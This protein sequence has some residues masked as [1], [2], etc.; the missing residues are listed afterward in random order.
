MAAALDRISEIWWFTLSWKYLIS[1]FLSEYIINCPGTVRAVKRRAITRT[2]KT[3]PS[4]TRSLCSSNEY[5]GSHRGGWRRRRRR[6]RRCLDNDDDD[7]RR[8][9][10]IPE[11]A[12][13]RHRG[14]GAAGH[15]TATTTP[16]AVAPEWLL[17]SRGASWASYRTTQGPHPKPPR[18]R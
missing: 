18:E 16:A 8:T 15:S 11:H 2:R 14:A 7:E 17:P 5:H 9:N 12:D 3:R 4:H 10:G 6:R 13:Y 1:R